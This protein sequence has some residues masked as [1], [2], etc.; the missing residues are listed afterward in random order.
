[1]LLSNLCIMY[2]R[3]HYLT[4]PLLVPAGAL[5]LRG[6]YDL[7]CIKESQGLNCVYIIEC[8]MKFALRADFSKQ[9]A[10]GLRTAWSVDRLFTIPN[11]LKHLWLIQNL[12]LNLKTAPQL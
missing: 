7:H 12:G 1:M 6:I 5:F 3:L 8:L 11:L 4:F 2:F 10:K 9:I